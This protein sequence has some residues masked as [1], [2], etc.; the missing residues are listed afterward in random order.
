MND[1]EE[2]AIRK[3][4]TDDLDGLVPLFDGYRRFYGN[5]SDLEGARR[6]LAARLAA[7]ESVIFVA[8]RAG[9]LLGF[10]QLYPSFSSGAMK[11][12]WILNDLF[13]TPAARRHGTGGALM[14]AAESFARDTGARGLVL[15]T[16]K[17]NANAKALYESRGWKIDAD[18]DHYLRFF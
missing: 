5:A 12:V 4:T 7:G 14:A 13:V 18:F 10:T 3:A 9:E 2:L 8:T 1:A 16:Q 6:F 17:T 11:R 15:A